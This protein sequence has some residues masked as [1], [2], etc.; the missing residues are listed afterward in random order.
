MLYILKNG[1]RKLNEMGEKDFVI[2]N[3]AKLNFGY[4]LT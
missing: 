2:V 4:T 1:E 3:K